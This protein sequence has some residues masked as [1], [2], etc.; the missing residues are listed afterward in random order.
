MGKAGKYPQ[1]FHLR[2]RPLTAAAGA[3]E[4]D[5]GTAGPVNG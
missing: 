1:T 4:L 2:E 5:V 3:D